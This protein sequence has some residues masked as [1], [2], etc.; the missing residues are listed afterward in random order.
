MV[1]LSDENNFSYTLKQNT[2]GGEGETWTTWNKPVLDAGIS[3]FHIKRKRY[4]VT[5]HS[6]L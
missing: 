3:W 1:I 4:F 6:S 5:E 2:R